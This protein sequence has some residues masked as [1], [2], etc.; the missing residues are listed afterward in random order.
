M[1]AASCED[2]AGR[3]YGPA[4]EGTAG[5]LAHVEVAITTG[6]ER[7]DILALAGQMNA[8]DDAARRAL[9]SGPRADTALAGA[10]AFV[11]GRPGA[12]KA[13]LLTG[14]GYGQGHRSRAIH[15]T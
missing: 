14:P 11:I 10:G 12:M 3:R 5:M 8:E 15:R 7:G 1:E 9:E 6:Q 13:P 4:L 2:W